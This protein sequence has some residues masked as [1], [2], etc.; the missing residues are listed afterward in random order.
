MKTIVQEDGQATTCKERIGEKE[1][2]NFLKNVD[3][4]FPEPLSDRVDLK[5]YSQKIYENAV[6]ITEIYDEKIVGMFAGYANDE[7]KEKA[8]VSFVSVIKEH[9]GNGIAKK[10]LKEFIEICKK[11][12]FQE[13]ELQTSLE[14][15]EAIKLYESNG[16]ERSF[17]VGSRVEYQY[18]IEE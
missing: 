8:Y 12:R 15:Q 7:K 9:R 10:L 16:F 17:V 18:K 6:I 2:Y 3:K 4:D 1:L 11:K 14:N 5:E 13:I